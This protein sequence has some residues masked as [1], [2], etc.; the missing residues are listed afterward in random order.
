MQEMLDFPDSIR[1]FLQ[2]GLVISTG[3]KLL[4]VL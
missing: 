4:A 1:Q 2:K 3:R